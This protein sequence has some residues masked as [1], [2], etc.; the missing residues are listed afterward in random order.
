MRYGRTLKPS[1]RTHSV[2]YDPS[3]TALSPLTSPLDEKRQRK[4]K[5][6]EEDEEEAV[7]TTN[8]EEERKRRCKHH[9][10]EVSSNGRKETSDT[11]SLNDMPLQRN[12]RALPHLT[13][14]L[15]RPHTP[16][17]QE[18]GV[19]VSASSK[20]IQSHQ[21]NGISLLKTDIPRQLDTQ[22]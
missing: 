11:W 13:R 2:P 5:E 4:D 6:E 19:L 8:M 14:P 10:F 18:G 16:L 20:D 15:A 17:Q 12:S 21:Y 22:L 1:G 7:T 3:P 9:I